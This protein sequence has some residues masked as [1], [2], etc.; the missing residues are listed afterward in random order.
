MIFISSK[1]AVHVQLIIEVVI[2]VNTNHSQISS[3]LCGT[4]AKRVHVIPLSGRMSMNS[5]VCGEKKFEIFLG[6]IHD[7]T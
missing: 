1:F 4:G 7:E 3:F 5:V 6:L 2:D